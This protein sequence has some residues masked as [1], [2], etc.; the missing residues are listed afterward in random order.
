MGLGNSDSEGANGWSEAQVFN[1][2]S[3]AG[4]DVSWLGRL[5]KRSGRSGGSLADAEGGKQF[6]QHGLVV[7]LSGDLAEGVK[8]LP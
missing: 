3:W 5:R 2:K 1:G 4:G 8:S 7:D 6:I